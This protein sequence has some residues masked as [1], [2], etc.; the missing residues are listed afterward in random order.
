MLWA[1]ANDQLTLT[2]AADQKGDGE[3]CALVTSRPSEEDPDNSVGN[4]HDLIQ[5]LR[6][7]IFS[8]E[9]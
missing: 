6:H 5:F 3:Y 1:I 2:N 4:I 8:Q 7:H 9:I